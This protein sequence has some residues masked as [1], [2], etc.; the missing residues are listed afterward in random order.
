MRYPEAP[1]RPE[2][3]EVGGLV[4]DDPYQWLEE[5]DREGVAAEG[6]GRA[7]PGL[8]ARLAAS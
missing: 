1:V 7:G 6:P 3:N 5:D 4:F 8:R 2:H